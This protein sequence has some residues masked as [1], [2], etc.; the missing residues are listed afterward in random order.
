M[1]RASSTTAKALAV[2]IS[3]AATF[4]AF[5]AAAQQ[6]ALSPTCARY[7]DPGSQAQC[8]Y[9][10]ALAAR[11]AHTQ[12]MRRETAEANQTTAAEQALRP[13]L[14]FLTAR[15]NAGAVFDRQITRENACSYA[16]QLGMQPS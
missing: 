6:V 8:T 1:L 14:E 5:P 10:E 12:Q 15:K 13:C 16:R 9:N 4:A 7:T 2:A 3:G 11:R